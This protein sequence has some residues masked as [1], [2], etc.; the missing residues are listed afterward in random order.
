M[1]I[2]NQ[3]RL[4]TENEVNNRS[5]SIVT[6][7]CGCFTKPKGISALTAQNEIIIVNHV[8]PKLDL[9]AAVF[10]TKHEIGRIHNNKWEKYSS[11]ALKS[12]SCF[13]SVL[14]VGLLFRTGFS[15]PIAIATVATS[16][17]TY[18]LGEK[19]SLARQHE[20]WADSFAIETAT[21]D[22]LRGGLRAF[23][24]IVQANRM[25]DMGESTERRRFKRIEEELMRRGEEID[26]N[27]EEGLKKI[28]DMI[29]W[30]IL[31]H[32]CGIPQDQKALFDNF[33][34]RYNL[35]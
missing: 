29:C 8:F 20:Y 9:D 23:E 18:W 28:Q 13:I 31:D 34:L 1:S 7:S 16:I 11:L 4:R 24:A 19:A 2:E 5:I 14:G 6:Y 26:T 12:M 32:S 22:E 33:K 30:Q 10:M 25:V 3:I 21:V 17:F 15:A 27:P 35:A